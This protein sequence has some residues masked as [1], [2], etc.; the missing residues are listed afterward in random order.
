MTAFK[1]KYPNAK[2][3]NLSKDGYKQKLEEVKTD[4]ETLKFHDNYIQVD[5]VE[6]KSTIG[7]IV[8]S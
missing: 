4:L 8:P 3:A 7:V 6:N 1:A 5:V 2:S